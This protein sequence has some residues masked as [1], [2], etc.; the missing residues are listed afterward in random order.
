MPAPQAL[1]KRLLTVIGGSVM[2]DLTP[3]GLV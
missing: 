3:A 2:V 1:Y